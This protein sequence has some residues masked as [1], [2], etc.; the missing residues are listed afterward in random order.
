[1]ALAVVTALRQQARSWAA[2]L[3]G[4]R[5]EVREAKARSEALADPDGRA[6]DRSPTAQKRLSYLGASLAATQ[7]LGTCLRL[8]E[9]LVRATAVTASH[10]GYDEAQVYLLDSAGEWATLVS[11]SRDDGGDVIAQGYRLRTDGDTVVGWVAASDRQRRRIMV[12]IHLTLWRRAPLDLSR[13]WLCLGERGTD[14]RRP[15]SPHQ[16]ET[17][18]SR[19]ELHVLEAFS[20]HLAYLIDHA[21]EVRDE[22]MASEAGGPFWGLQSAGKRS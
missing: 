12:V 7:Q 21:R 2:G 17:D 13:S 16:R 10:F 11:T 1:M 4:A 20:D 5:E 15:G 6:R 18:V 19:E 22:A 8:G 14:P 9:L 3:A